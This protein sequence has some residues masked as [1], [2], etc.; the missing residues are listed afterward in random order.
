MMSA[1]KAEQRRRRR[2]QGLK[3]LEVWLPEQLILE[4]DQ[5][6]TEQTHSREAVIAALIAATLQKA[7]PGRPV[8]SMALG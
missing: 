5:L 6:K 4:I 7:R 1:R 8:A 3:P 2:A